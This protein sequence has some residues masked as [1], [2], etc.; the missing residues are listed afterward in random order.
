VSWE[1]EEQV[2]NRLAFCFIDGDHTMRG[3]PRDV[4]TWP[5]KVK[6]GG[7]IA[8]HDYGVPNPYVVVKCIVDAW[9]F[10]VQWEELGTVGSLIAFRKLDGDRN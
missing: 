8:F 10:K 3:I 1:V 6:P 7:V 4:L 9:Q 5:N 2:L